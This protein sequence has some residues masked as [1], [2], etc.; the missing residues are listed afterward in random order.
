M[1]ACWPRSVSWPVSASDPAGEEARLNCAR[2]TAS[3]A[4]GIVAGC[5]PR[6]ARARSHD[7]GEGAVSA[8]PP[9]PRNASIRPPLDV[10]ADAEQHEAAAEQDREATY[11]TWTRRLRFPFRSKSM[12][13]LRFPGAGS[14]GALGAT[15]RRARARLRGRPSSDARTILNSN[16]ITSGTVSSTIE[17][18]STVGSS[19]ASTTITK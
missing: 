12:G 4:S 2:T 3:Q 6:G 8:P 15:A 19:A 16:R 9:P 7:V 10:A 5:A 13:F 1:I 18:G 11:T 14:G 17:T